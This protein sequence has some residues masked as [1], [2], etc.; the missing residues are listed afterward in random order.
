MGCCQCVHDKSEQDFDGAEHVLHKKEKSPMNMD[1]LSYDRMTRRRRIFENQKTY[2]NQHIQ[3]SEQYESG[4]YDNQHIQESEQ[5]ERGNYENKD[6]HIY[7]YIQQSEQYESLPHW[8]MDIEDEE[9]IFFDI[10]C[11][12]AKIINFEINNDSNSNYND[13][14]SN[15]TESDDKSGKM[16]LRHSSTMNQHKRVQNEKEMNYLFYFIDDK[17]N[18]SKIMDVIIGI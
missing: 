9:Q 12:Y 16:Q 13:T 4:N 17:F 3:E 7:A 14:D 10:M 5:Y 2:L 18:M 15:S 1:I 8:I 6:I 11:Q